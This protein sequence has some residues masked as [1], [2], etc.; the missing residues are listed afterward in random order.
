[1]TPE[2]F[3]QIRIDLKLSV[4]EMAEYLG[5]KSG[6]TIRKYEAGELPVSEQAIMILRSKAIEE[7]KA[8]EDK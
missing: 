5:L 8:K 6:R 1:M 7:E 2:E 4:Q 3:R